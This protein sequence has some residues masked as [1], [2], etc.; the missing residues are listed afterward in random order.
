MTAPDPIALRA[1]YSTLLRA[2]LAELQQRS[3][4]TGAARA[5][6]MLD[7]QSVGRV[8]RMDALQHQ[9]MAQG[10][11]ARRDARI[12]AIHAALQRLEEED[13]GWCDEC[14]EPI[15]AKRLDLD[16]TVMRCIDCAR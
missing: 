4:D 3:R 11:Q 14:G 9:A 2:E 10:Q 8:S 7:Q 1:R 6:V 5:P 12:K 13:F 16:P 15:A